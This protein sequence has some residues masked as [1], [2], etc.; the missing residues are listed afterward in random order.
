MR[1]SPLPGL[2][3]KSPL[4]NENNKEIKEVSH[5]TEP[6]TGPKVMGGS[7]P[8][9]AKTIMSIYNTGKRIYNKLTS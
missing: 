8:N 2:I 1:N 4:R 6:Y 3:K 5:A 9:P 7:A